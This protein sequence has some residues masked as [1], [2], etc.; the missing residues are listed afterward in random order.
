MSTIRLFPGNHRNLTVA[1]FDN[2]AEV[3]EIFADKDCDSYIGCADTLGEAL[4][5][6]N[7]WINEE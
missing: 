3:F 5:I 7:A 6:S 2:G 1:V 4:R